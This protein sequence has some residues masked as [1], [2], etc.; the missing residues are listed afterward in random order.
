MEPH[1]E[2]GSEWVSQLVNGGQK[3]VKSC[4]RQLFTK[5]Y[6]PVSILVSRM[7]LKAVVGLSVPAEA[8]LIYH[9][10]GHKSHF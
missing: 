4:Y 3:Q 7:E 9:I 5:Y 6:S 1:S 10:K 2:P 8:E